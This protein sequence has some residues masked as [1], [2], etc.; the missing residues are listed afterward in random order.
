MSLTRRSVQQALQT[1]QVLRK[2]LHV[3]GVQEVGQLA[4]PGDAVAVV[5]GDWDTTAAGRRC[6][7]SQGPSERVEV[8][9]EQE[10][11]VDGAFGC[12]TVCRDGV[13]ALMA[14][15]HEQLL[16]RHAPV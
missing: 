5:H 7:S 15:L 2:A 1:W 3:V 16:S 14:D 8:H 6:R 4:L 13:T 12:A 9:C 10:W 11:T